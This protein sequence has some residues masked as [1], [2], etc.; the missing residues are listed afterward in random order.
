MKP[1]L[2]ARAPH[3]D[4]RF[5]PGSIVVGQ[6]EGKRL[7]TISA[8][9]RARHVHLT[10]ATGMG[11]TTCMSSM[12]WQDM[13]EPDGVR[14]SVLVFDPHGNEAHGQHRRAVSYGIHR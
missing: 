2:P 4:W 5:P 10:G 13:L 8:E 1:G 3:P 11:K 14:R 9:M 7:Q 12:I 6:T